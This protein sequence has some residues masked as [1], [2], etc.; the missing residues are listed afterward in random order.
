SGDKPRKIPRDQRATSNVSIICLLRLRRW[1]ARKFLGGCL[2]RKPHGL[3]QRAEIV[4]AVEQDG[5]PQRVAAI[6]H[7]AEPEADAEDFTEEEPVILQ[8]QAG[9]DE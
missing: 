1:K 3:H 9:P 5:Q 2:P 4:E 8:V 6:A 7:V